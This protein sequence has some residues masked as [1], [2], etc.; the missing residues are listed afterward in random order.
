[1][2]K[3]ILKIV[4]IVIAV[5]FLLAIAL[6][7]FINV[8]HFRPEIESNVSAALGRNVTLGDLSLSILSGSVEANQLA[9]ADDPKFSNT[10]FMQAKS[11]KVGVELIPLIFAKQ[12]NVTHLVIDH[13]QIALLRT[14]DGVWNFS[15]LGAHAG[16]A[17]KAPA[18]T[19]GSSS[20]QNL[21]VDKLEIS[22][23]TI[24]V[25]S[26]PPHRAPIV[27]DNVNVSVKNFS[28]TS[29]F[30]VNV[31]V[32]LPGGGSLKLDATAGPINPTDA[33]LTPLQGTVKLKKL[34]LSRSALVNPETGIAGSADFDGTVNSDG[35]VAKA[36]GTVKAS[37]LKLVPKGS[38][39]PQTVQVVFA[40]DHDL[41]KETG[42]LTQGD[43]TV[44]KA[45]M[46]LS[47]TY[48]MHGEETSVHM[49]LTGQSMPVDYLEALL[50]ALGVTLPTGSKLKNGTLNMDF[51]AVGPVDKI[52]ATGTVRMTNAK[53]EGFNLT[54]KLSAIP[55]LGGKS[56]GND[57]DIE[58]LSSNVH[59]A[60]DGI[61]LDQIN[62]VIPSIGTVTGAG[63]V[64]PNKELDFKMVANLS[65]AVGGGLTRVAG[66]GSGG[67]P[68][69]VGGTT[70][71]PTF[72]PDMKA[73]AGSQI[74]NLGTAG[75]SIGKVGGL[76]GKKKN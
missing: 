21:S 50:P 34:D 44:G 1:M 33:A 36:T 26:V 63:T 23:G 46:K 8:N 28:F 18:K 40:V 57:T 64:S 55:G 62:V 35:Q 15:S 9:V 47:G 54:S 70:S 2:N 5:L 76:F 13:P 37:G 51:D 17:A 30:P 25:G 66:L 38:P 12:I 7:L 48:D 20:P 65:G 24:S 67:I 29:Q 16:D 73:L 72:M 31:S 32:E 43:V 45:N 53:L 3:K 49:K 11:L 75:K 10:P 60:P 58:N 39:S 42:Q 22:D 6:P 56:T 27:Y 68:V 59:Y 61:R 74:K 52:V 4:G 19:G 71:S 69:K 41:Q 14:R